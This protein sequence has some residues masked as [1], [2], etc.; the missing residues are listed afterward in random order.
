MKGLRGTWLGVA[1]I[2]HEQ[3]TLYRGNEGA[4]AT[5]IEVAD[6]LRRLAMCS[7]KDFDQKVFIHVVEHGEGYEN[8]H[9]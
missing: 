7:S 9:K 3:R 6:A 5:L 8:G 4:Q 1:R 2:L